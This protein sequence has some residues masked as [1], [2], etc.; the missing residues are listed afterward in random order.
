[1][2]LHIHPSA[3]VDDS[4]RI[5]II[6]AASYVGSAAADIL[7]TGGRACIGFS[8]Q[9]RPAD[10]H[11]WRTLAEPAGADRI[12][13]WI[14]VGPIWTFAERR[15]AMKAYGATKIVITSSTSRFTKQSSGSKKETETAERLRAGEENFSRW[16]EANQIDWIILRPT[17]IYGLG[18]DKNVREIAAMIRKVGM[19]PIF[20]AGN[21]LRQPIHAADLAMACVQALDADTQNKAYNVSG[22]QVLTY[23][24]MVREVFRALGRRPVTPTVPLPLFK[25]ACRALNLVPRF[26]HWTPQMAERMNADMA[27]DHSDATADFGF[28]PRPFR[29]EPQDLA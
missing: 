25:L 26:A 6:G 10:R 11:E 23:R 18:R 16:C 5:G 20:G 22:G 7:I 27:F 13:N 14:D 12:E 21:G 29:L 17:L 28:R 24:D 15:E 4:A 9:V 8:R 3:I 2:P 1:M 19:F